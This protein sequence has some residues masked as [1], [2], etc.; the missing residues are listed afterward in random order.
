MCRAQALQLILYHP[1]NFISPHTILYHPYKYLPLFLHY[2]YTK[3][4]KFFQKF[5]M[6]PHQKIFQKIFFYTPTIGKF[7]FSKI[8]CYNIYRK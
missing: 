6:L 8:L 5:F 2:P 3:I 1:Y 7:A 4:L